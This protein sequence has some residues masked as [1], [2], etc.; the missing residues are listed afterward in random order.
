VTGFK[1]LPAGR[2]FKDSRGPGIKGSTQIRKELEKIGFLR[3]GL[4][5][6]LT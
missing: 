5:I 1:D 2:G 3:I 4:Q 6:I